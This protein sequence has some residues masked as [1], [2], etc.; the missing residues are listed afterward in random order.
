MLASLLAYVT[1]FGE[2]TSVRQGTDTD[3][4]VVTPQGIVLVDVKTS[5]VAGAAEVQRLARVIERPSRFT[6][7]PFRAILLVT[8][9]VLVLR[10]AA[11]LAR[12]GAVDIVSLALPASG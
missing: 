4:E 3:F 9:D 5:G 7:Q 10:E 11:E 1:G 2:E 8:P 6:E 12:R